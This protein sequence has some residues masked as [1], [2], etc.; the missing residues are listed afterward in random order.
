MTKEKLTQLFELLDKLNDGSVAMLEERLHALSTRD[1]F[2][3]QSQLTLLAARLQV[4][5]SA[6][7][8][9]HP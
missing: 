3:L 5:A 8:V 1:E 4:M 2:V 7:P 6:R 9:R